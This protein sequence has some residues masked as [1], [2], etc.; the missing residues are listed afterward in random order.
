M[1]LYFVP[2]EMHLVCVSSKCSDLIR[3]S[4]TGLL[5]YGLQL[6]LRRSVFFPC[7]LCFWQGVPKYRRIFLL[8]VVEPDTNIQLLEH[9]FIC[10]MFCPWNSKYSSIYPH[11]NDINSVCMNFNVTRRSAIGESKDISSAI[12]IYLRS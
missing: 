4:A 6:R 9:G 7:P 1:L 12:R 8:T 2:C 11:L 3:S 10:T 5:I